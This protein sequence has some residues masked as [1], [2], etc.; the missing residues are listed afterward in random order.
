MLDRL[1]HVAPGSQRCKGCRGYLYRHVAIRES[2]SATHAYDSLGANELASSSTCVML[3]NSMLS[4][5]IVWLF[6][7][8]LI[9]LVAHDHAALE[10]ALRWHRQRSANPPEWYPPIVVVRPIRGIDR[11]FEGNIEAAIIN[12]YPGRLETIFVFDD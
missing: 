1:Q 6:G 3:E 9:V 8:G 7:A 12:D 11:G 5:L 2:C 10:F 4:E